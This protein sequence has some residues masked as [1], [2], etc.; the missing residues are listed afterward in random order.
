L[1]VN[2]NKRTA[3]GIL[4]KDERDMNNPGMA[5]PLEELEKACQSKSGKAPGIDGILA[6]AELLKALGSRGK[7]ELYEI[8]NNIY[9]S[10]EW[11]WDVL[12]SIIIPTEK[13]NGAQECMDFRTISLISHASKLLRNILARMLESK[14]ESFLELDQYDFKRGCGTRDAI[15]AMQVVR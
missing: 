4:V 10:G 6:P 2:S 8:Y 3:N 9:N 13:K 5:L 11:P 1:Y 12:E 14:A 15:A 7:Q